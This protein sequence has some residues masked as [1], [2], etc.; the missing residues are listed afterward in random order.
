MQLYT[1]A[2]LSGL[3]YTDSTSN[4]VPTSRKAASKAPQSSAKS[5][6]SVIIYESHKDDFT[7]EATVRSYS[8]SHDCTVCLKCSCGV[9][10]LKYYGYLS[11]AST[12]CTTLSF[13]PGA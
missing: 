1:G 6:S 5:Y 12:L 13:P 10:R 9:S 2:S 8:R 4:S 3:G 7:L 11:L